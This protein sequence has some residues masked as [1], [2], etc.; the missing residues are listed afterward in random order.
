[1]L[2]FNSTSQEAVLDSSMKINSE[3]RKVTTPSTDVPNTNELIDK[4]LFISFLALLTSSF[5]VYISYLTYRIQRKHN[6]NSIKPYL[7]IHPF[8]YE[9]CIKLELK[10]QGLGVAIIKSFEVFKD[11]VKKENIFKWLPEK[12]PS[13]INYEDYFLGGINDFPISSNNLLNILEVKF[14]NSKKEQIF[15]R[16]HIRK[17]LSHLSIKIEYK[18][19]Y[20]NVFFLEQNLEIFSRT[21][22]ENSNKNNY[23]KR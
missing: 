23:G 11:T 10:N 13:G 19:I 4:N 9:D 3:V 17:I 14:D 7:I 5:A 2:T 15:L 18:D 20:E 16:N 12:L 22:N 1:M 8:D 6:I 21:D